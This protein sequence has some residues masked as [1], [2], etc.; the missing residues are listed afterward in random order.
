MNIGIMYLI[1]K[2]NVNDNFNYLGFDLSRFDY[3]VYFDIIICS[4]IFEPDYYKIIICIM[5]IKF[6]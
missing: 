5:G 6:T 4:L 2:S 3:I 1:R